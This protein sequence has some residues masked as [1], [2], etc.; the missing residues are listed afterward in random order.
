M[1]MNKTVKKLSIRQMNKMKAALVLATPY[2]GNI[3]SLNQ[4]TNIHYVVN[5]LIES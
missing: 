3:K 2:D 5:T 4:E 1:E